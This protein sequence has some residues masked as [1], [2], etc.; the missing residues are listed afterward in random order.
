[1]DVILY[2]IKDDLPSAVV[3]DIHKLLDEIEGVKY[4]FDFKAFILIV[5]R[6]Q[7]IC[8]S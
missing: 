5:R 8:S 6:T 4:H 1:M 7:F 2:L 3:R